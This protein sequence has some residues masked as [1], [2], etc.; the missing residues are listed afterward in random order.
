MKL[1]FEWDKKKAWFNL[2][3]HR[4]SFVV[5]ADRT[6]SEDTLTIRII[7][8]RKATPSERRNYEEGYEQF[9]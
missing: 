5:H 2:Q 3:K 9:H 4:V 7:S 1:I 8:C 6:E